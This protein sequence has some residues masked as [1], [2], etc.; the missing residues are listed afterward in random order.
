VYRWVEA[1]GW[2][3][4]SRSPYDL[5]GFVWKKDD[6]PPGFAG[7]WKGGTAPPPRVGLA[8]P[9]QWATKQ[10]TDRPPFLLKQAQAIASYVAVEGLR[11]SND[12]LSKERLRDLKGAGS[13]VGAG[14]CGWTFDA[15]SVCSRALVRRD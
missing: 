7:I 3:L 1:W 5:L 15:L 9:R 11:L 12:R 2:G 4:F 10:P 8:A 14:F 6:P 13:G